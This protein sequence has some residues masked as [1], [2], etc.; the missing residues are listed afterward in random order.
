MLMPDVFLCEITYNTVLTDAVFSITVTCPELARESVAG[1]FLHIKCG[2]ERLLRRPISICSIRGDEVRF[3][4]EVKGEGTRWLSECEKGQRL[5]ILGPLGNGFTMPEGNL[6]IVGGGVGTPPMLFAAESAKKNVM[7]VLGF[8]SKDRVILTNEFKAL[9]D[10]VYI[11]TDDGSAG[12][13]GMVT[14][15]LEA[16]LKKGGYDAV[17]SCGQLIMQ[18][19][20]AELCARYNIPCQVSVEER[21]GCGVGACLV[22]ACETVTN[23]VRQ[24]SRA[25]TDGPV[26][27]ASEVVW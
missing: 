27:D 4:F 9:C 13:H 12:I 20:V 17:M 7:A 25:C 1:Q 16:L 3:V 18:K 6:I 15:P 5:D 22:C 14:G 10:E 19:A 11:T 24:M 21:M 26:F 8:R 2:Q 23:G